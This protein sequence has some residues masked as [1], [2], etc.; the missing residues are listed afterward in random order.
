[1]GKFV[2][3]GQ[4]LWI[5]IISELFSFGNFFAPGS[6]THTAGIGNNKVTK[7]SIFG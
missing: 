2:Q 4:K 5:F 1:M 6:I 7:K 3:V